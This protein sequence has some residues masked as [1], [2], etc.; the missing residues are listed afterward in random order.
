MKRKFKIGD[1]VRPV[2]ASIC[3]DLRRLEEGPLDAVVTKLSLSTDPR[4]DLVDIRFDDD[5]VWIM[6]TADHLESA[7]VIPDAGPTV[8]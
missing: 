3:W 2:P 7:A 8:V 4:L 1:R 6:V 5:A